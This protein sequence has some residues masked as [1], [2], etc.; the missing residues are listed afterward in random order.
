MDTE[1]HWTDCSVL[2]YATR[3]R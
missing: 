3:I 1:D 2:Q